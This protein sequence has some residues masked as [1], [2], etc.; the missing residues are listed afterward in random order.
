MAASPQQG[1]G[2]LCSGLDHSGISMA[3]LTGS[4]DAKGCDTVQCPYLQ[5]SARDHVALT[6]C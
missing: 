3:T 4:G 6:T 2:T 5:V 1:S